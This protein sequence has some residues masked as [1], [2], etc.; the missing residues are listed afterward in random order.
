MMH[1]L[2]LLFWLLVGHALADYPL[3]GNFMSY[4][5]NR[6]ISGNRDIWPGVLCSHGLIHG[7][8]VYAITGSL[9]LGLLETVAHCIIDDLKCSGALS[10]NQGQAAHIG[11]K[12][13]WLAFLP[14][15][16]A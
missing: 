2:S 16:L 5:K 7:G 4:A 3:Q 9:I 6:R 8:F 13:V 15:G 12:L 11:C 10:F 1:D 14:V